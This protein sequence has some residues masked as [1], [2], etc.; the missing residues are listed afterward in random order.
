MSNELDALDIEILRLLIENCNRSARELAR[1][2]NRS[3]TTI[4]ARIRKLYNLG[5]VKRCTAL[6]NH[7][8][9]G[10]RIMALIM[11]NVDGSHL[12]TIEK[13]LAAKPNVRAVY[14]IAGDYNVAA[15]ALFRDVDELNEFLRQVTRDPHVRRSSVN[16][17][18]KVVK[19]EPNIDL[20]T[21]L[22]LSRPELR[23][24]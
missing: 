14:D 12:D 11:L 6:V 23:S 15:I 3:P 20:L 1:E 16:L 17:V 10:F 7:R 22:S 9:L 18:L 21:L 13:N 24:S 2:L 8:A 19:D 4:I 5:I